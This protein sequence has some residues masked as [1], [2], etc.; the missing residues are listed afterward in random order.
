MLYYLP[1]CMTMIRQY[2]SLFLFGGFTKIWKQTYFGQL[3]TK[4]KKYH[5]SSVKKQPSVT[6]IVQLVEILC[7]T[8]VHTC[9][10]LL[11]LLSV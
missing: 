7:Q 1:T 5:Y 2:L 10:V 6:L 9:T 11:S 8:V 3:Y 4:F